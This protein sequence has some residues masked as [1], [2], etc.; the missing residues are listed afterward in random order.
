MKRNTI[1]LALALLLALAQGCEASKH[2][3]AADATNGDATA[4]DGTAADAA[5]TDSG[6]SMGGMDM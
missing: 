1:L 6:N 4:A 3:D 2:E 5:A